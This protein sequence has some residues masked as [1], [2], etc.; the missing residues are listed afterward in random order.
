MFFTDAYDE[1]TLTK[2]DGSVDTRIVMHFS[3]VLAPVK[4]AV[5]PLVKKRHAEK[6]LELRKEFSYD[7]ETEYDESGS[8]GKRYRRMDEIGTPYCITVDDETLEN[9][10]VTIRYRDS[11]EQERMTVEEVRTLITKAIRF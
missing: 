5:L 4:A 2:E 7:F 1:E 11:M 3:P 9:G 8:I 10:T 6:A